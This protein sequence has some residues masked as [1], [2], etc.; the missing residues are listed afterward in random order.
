MSRT[1][2]TIVFLFILVGSGAQS[3]DRLQ[4]VQR[5]DA[6]QAM[7]PKTYVHLVFNQNKYSPGD[8]VWFKAYF[9][10]EDLTG[11]SGKQ[12]IELN[13]VDSVGASKLHLLF[14]VVDGVGHNQLVIPDELPA[15]VYLITA[16]SSWMKNFDPPLFSIKRMPIVVK[17]ELM[18]AEAKSLQAVPEG[19]HLIYGIPCKVGIRSNR[20][21][22]AIQLVDAEGLEVGSTTTDSNGIGAI[23][24][25]PLKKSY[26]ARIIG[27][28]TQTALPLTKEDGCSLFLQPSTDTEPAKIRITS[29]EGSPLRNQELMIIV[30]SL[31]K[32]QFTQMLPPTTGGIV[33]AL[34]PADLPPGVLQVSLLNQRGDLLASRDFYN[35]GMPLVKPTLL[36]SKQ[37]YKTREKISMEVTLTDQAGKPVMGEFSIK[38]LN[39]SLF[40]FDTENL[41]TDELIILSGAR[42]EFHINRSDPSWQTSLDN[43]L[44]VTT[45]PI[46]WKEILSGK[47]PTPRFPFTS[48]IEKTGT[49]YTNDPPVPVPDLTQILFY[50]QKNQMIYQTFTLAD[51]KVGLTIPDIFEPDEFFFMAQTRG[52]DVS[53]FKIQWDESPIQLPKAPHF[54]EANED[55]YASF[56][57]KRKLIEKSYSAYGNQGDEG[58][59]INNLTI[60]SFEDEI[61]EADI[62]VKIQDYNSFQDMVEMIKEVV[63]SMY[64]RKAGK[65]SIVRVSLQ[66]PMAPASKDPLYIIDGIATTNTDFFLSLKPADLVTLKIVNKPKKLIPLGLMGKNGIVMVQ[67][68]NGNVREPLADASKVVQGISRPLSFKVQNQKHSHS[69]PDFRSTLYWNPAIKT[70]ADGKAT[71]EFYGSDDVGELQIRIDGFS[72]GG[73]P[74]SATLKV[75]VAT[76]PEMD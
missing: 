23:I 72:S 38:V 36:T 24:F 55:V 75:R 34:L 46:P 15:G 49:A 42:G 54:R 47:L 63:P 10:N 43:L 65:K 12:F 8:T 2:V 70:N 58:M 7:W 4:I 66:Q 50:L 40:N 33:E 13:L 68:K 17:N 9:L 41:L 22:A 53:N 27:D 6:Y 20:K 59:I 39:S 44:L 16:H 74:F 71:V 48:V 64:H 76:N 57:T 19:G 30:S 56:A 73:R 51:G 5:Y 61:N 60:H 28:T 26:V 69:N 52:K 67:T 37:I 32:I 21:N 3:I 11:V 25:T 14:S 18:L 45:N 29:P 31:S 62:V 35:D 1:W